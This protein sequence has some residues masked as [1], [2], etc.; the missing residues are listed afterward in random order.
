MLFFIN[1]FSSQNIA[2]QNWEMHLNL[3]GIEGLIKRNSGSVLMKRKLGE[4]TYARLGLEGFLDT[5]S[6]TA[7][8]GS[9]I[10]L[11]RNFIMQFRP[12]IERRNQ[13]TDKI[14]FLW[15]TELYYARSGNDV[16]PPVVEQYSFRQRVNY[17]GASPFVGLHYNINKNIAILGETHLLGIGQFMRSTIKNELS[18][19]YPNRIE[20]RRDYYVR[21]RPFQY[22]TLCFIF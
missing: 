21:L 1:C 3:R 16:V 11:E 14:S 12:G 20:T 4:K 9:N 10:V 17:V 5:K 22:L 7:K 13:L 19:T 8:F 15:G 2:A 18:S 6:Q